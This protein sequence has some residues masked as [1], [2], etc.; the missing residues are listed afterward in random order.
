MKAKRYIIIILGALF[1]WIQVNGQDAG[2]RPLDKPFPNLY[3]QFA[4]VI[5]P[6]VQ[7]EAFGNRAVQKLF[8][9]ADYL[10]LISDREYDMDFRNKAMG[11]A[12]DLFLDKSL[13][14]PDLTRHE[15][16]ISMTTVGNFLSVISKSKAFDKVEATIKSAEITEEAG[17]EGQ[18]GYFGK[19]R[20][21][22]ELVGK[23][24][25]KEVFSESYNGE[26][27][28]S[29]IQEIKKFGNK[30]RPVWESKLGKVLN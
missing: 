17:R 14:F 27:E 5:L 8:D 3:N 24:K 28:F 7:L 25:G 29:I 9:F 20:F 6:D 16:P 2:H 30:N 1:S 4:Y 26:I 15:A 10:N 11:M 13:D 12:E 18:T 22:M 23:M 19:I 21:E